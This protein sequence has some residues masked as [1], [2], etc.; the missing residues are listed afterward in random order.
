MFIWIILAICAVIAFLFL[1]KTFM[2]SPG[3]QASAVV[4]NFYAYGTT[5]NFHA[6]GPFSLPDARK[7]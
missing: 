6:Y 7:V 5:G 1:G 2:F 3:R 4:K